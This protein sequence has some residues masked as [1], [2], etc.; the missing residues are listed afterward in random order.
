MKFSSLF[1]ST[2]LYEANIIILEAEAVGAPKFITTYQQ[3]VH[4]RALML[5]HKGTAW[6][7]VLLQ[8]FSQPN[9]KILLWQETFCCAIC[10]ISYSKLSLTGFT[11][12]ILISI[13]KRQY[14]SEIL[15]LPKNVNEWLSKKD[16]AIISVFWVQ[17][18]EKAN[19]ILYVWNI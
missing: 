11:L 8:P 17:Y 4:V 7:L 19:S 18:D 9:H 12:N 3:I 15:S 16:F 5:E 1:T 13:H 10:I 2:K 6:V 14:V